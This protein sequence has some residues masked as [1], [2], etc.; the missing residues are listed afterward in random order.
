V[1]PSD[2][3]GPACHGP[4]AAADPAGDDEDENEIHL[5]QFWDR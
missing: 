4:D 2:T 5:A 1:Y 3:T